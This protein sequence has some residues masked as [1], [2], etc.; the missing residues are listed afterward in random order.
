MIKDILLLQKRELELALKEFY[1]ERE[2]VKLDLNNPLI[3]V[4]IGPR[5]AGNL[6]SAFTCLVKVIILVT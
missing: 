4:I 1:L 2:D 6:F 5:R 3:K